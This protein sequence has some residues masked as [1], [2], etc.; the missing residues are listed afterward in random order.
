MCHVARV[1]LHQ[2]LSH[3]VVHHP[4]THRDKPVRGTEDLH[5]RIHPGLDGPSLLCRP[6]DLLARKPNERA[7]LF[8]QRLCLVRLRMVDR[9]LQLLVKGR[10]TS[11]VDNILEALHMSAVLEFGHLLGRLVPHRLAKHQE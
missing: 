10:W 4:G 1:P 6:P 3:P 9:V 2:L 8:I 7:E 5:H 11:L